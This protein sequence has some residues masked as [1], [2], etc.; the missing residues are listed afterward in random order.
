MRTPSSSDVVNRHFSRGTRVGVVPEAI[1]HRQ[2]R[3]ADRSRRREDR[4]ADQ[5]GDASVCFS[6]AMNEK[7]TRPV[8]FAAGA[9]TRQD[10]RLDIELPADPHERVALFHQEAVAEV[11]RGRRILTAARGAIEAP[12]DALAP[13]VGDLEEQ[14]A[15]ASCGVHGL[16]H[17]EIGGEVHAAIAPRVGVFEIDDALVVRS[18]GSSANSIVPV[19]FSYGPD[20]IRTPGRPATTVAMAM[21]TFVTSAR[22]VRRPD[23]RADDECEEPTRM[24]D[25]IESSRS[26]IRSRRSRR[27]FESRQLEHRLRHDRVVVLATSR[28]HRGVQQLLDDGRH[29]RG[30]V[31]LGQR[32]DHVAHVLRE[33]MRL[34]SRL[35]G[36]LERTLAVHFEHAALGEAAEQRFA[37]FARV[38]AGL[39]RERERFGDDG[40]R[41]ADH[42]L[43]AQLAQLTRTR[44]A[45]V[46]DLLGIPHH[47]EDAA[48]RHANA[49]CVAADHDRERA[50][51]GADVAAADR[52]VEHRRATCLRAFGKPT[53]RTR[54]DAAH[55]DDDGAWLQRR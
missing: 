5:P 28:G 8:T 41:A 54:R 36:A 26:G 32:R 17:V 40:Q 49:C 45:D 52:R 31:V 9:S 46:H 53:G 39:A 2:R 47:V 23:E 30:A 50:V 51:D 19:S 48:S 10:R 4:R 6:S 27:L 25:R 3:G 22:A 29:G 42:H 15:V 33:Q 11:G 7:R 35:V 18:A 38:D 21:V 43:V 24:F 34:E 14:R 37:N 1:A 13:P 55:V 16:K 12:E 44:L 20:L